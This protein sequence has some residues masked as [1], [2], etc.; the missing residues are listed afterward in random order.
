MCNACGFACCAWDGF[1]GCGCDHCSN[2][3]CWEVCDEC[4]EV[5]CA[6]ECMGEGEWDSPECRED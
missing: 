6:G 1:G 5:G 3:E 4:G 2:P